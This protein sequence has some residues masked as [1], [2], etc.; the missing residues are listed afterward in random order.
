MHKSAI[1]SL[2]GKPDSIARLNSISLYLNQG[3]AWLAGCSLLLLILVVVV[4]AI[5]RV[6]YAPFSGATEIAGWLTAVSIAFGLG[7]TQV[8]RGYVEIDA[9]VERLPKGLQLTIKRIMLFISMIFYSLVAWQITVYGLNVMNNGN[10]SETMQ[11]P[12]YPLIFL[13]SLGFAGLTLALLVDFVKECNGGA[14]K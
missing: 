3:L 7:Y 13:L 9:L 10:L 12:F 6:F 1:A 11:L 2:P 4:N 5:M 8:K 14:G